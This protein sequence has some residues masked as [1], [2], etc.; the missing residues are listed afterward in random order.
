M[1]TTVDYPAPN[2]RDTFVT[3][4]NSHGVIVGYAFS[5]DAHGSPLPVISFIGT[6]Q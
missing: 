6:P 5:Y 4:I 3:G 1:I 2:V